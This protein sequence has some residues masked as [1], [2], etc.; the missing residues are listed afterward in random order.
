M[1]ILSRIFFAILGERLLEQFECMHLNLNLSQ[2]FSHIEIQTLNL[3]KN[4][5]LYKIHSDLLMKKYGLFVVDGEKTVYRL[6]ESN[7]QISEVICLEKY[8][9]VEFLK[10]FSKHSPIQT[11]FVAEPEQLKEIRGY[12]LHQGIMALAYVPNLQPALD[13]PVFI[14]NRILEANNWGS[15]IRSL[16]ALGIQSLV[17]D[18]HSCHPY[19]RRSVRVSMGTIFQMRIRETKKLSEFLEDFSKKGIP[20][21][22]TGIPKLNKKIISFFDWNPPKESIVVLGNEDQGIDLDLEKYIQEFVFIPMH[23]SVDSLNVA[24]AGA[25]LATKFRLNFS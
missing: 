15:L 5:E 13:F 25:I 17:F 20:I 21:Y 2:N 24:V 23:S 11:L 12:E 7:L 1:A 9:N 19:I 8:I 6:L 3:N 10:L 4:L 16:C 14:G 22:G 18:E